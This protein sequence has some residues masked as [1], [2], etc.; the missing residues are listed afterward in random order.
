MGR[1][2]V[3]VTGAADVTRKEDDSG[4]KSFKVYTQFTRF[5]I[6]ASAKQIQECLNG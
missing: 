2:G 6:L 1:A 5:S 3:K 4:V